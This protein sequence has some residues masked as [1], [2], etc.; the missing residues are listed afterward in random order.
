MKSPQK[1]NSIKIKTYKNPIK[2]NLRFQKFEQRA[3]SITA[4]KKKEKKIITLAGNGK[5]NN[6][7]SAFEIK[8]K[9]LNLSNKKKFSN[10]KERK[11]L[12]SSAIYSSTRKDRFKIKK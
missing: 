10:S 4:R 8:M 5:L 9:N 11:K 3:K 6:A 2:K 7:S 12:N 1:I